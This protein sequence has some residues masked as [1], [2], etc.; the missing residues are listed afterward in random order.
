MS[1]ESIDE[2]ISDAGLDKETRSG[3]TN[4]TRVDEEAL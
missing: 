3:G 4:L 1:F 2:F